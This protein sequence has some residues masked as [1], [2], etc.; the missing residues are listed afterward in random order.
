MYKPETVLENA[1]HK[2][3][4]EFEIQTDYL[5]PAR[6]PDIDKRKKKAC[7]LMDFA[8]TTEWK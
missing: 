4:W 8:V 3:L 6:Q 1:M 5:I 2:F 7:H